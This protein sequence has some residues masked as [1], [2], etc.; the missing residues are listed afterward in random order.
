[1]TKEK[2]V[3]SLAPTSLNNIFFQL[4]S[5]FWRSLA[6]HTKFAEP[7]GPDKRSMVAAQGLEP[8]TYGL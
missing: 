6:C 3:G 1:M 7:E 8:R 2:Q 4:K 5:L